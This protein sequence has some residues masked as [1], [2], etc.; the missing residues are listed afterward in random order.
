MHCPTSNPTGRLL[1]EGSV[2]ALK[3]KLGLH[4]Y[5]TNNYA[6]REVVYAQKKLGQS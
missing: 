1:C 2:I 5:W 3:P 4:Q 6:F